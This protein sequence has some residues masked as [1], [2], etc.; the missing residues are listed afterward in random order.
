MLLLRTSSCAL[1]QVVAR[2]TP[3]AGTPAPLTQPAPLWQIG[4]HPAIAPNCGKLMG[5]RNGIDIDI[6]DP[7]TDKVRGQLRRRAK[8]LRKAVLGA[9][10]KSAK[11]WGSARPLPLRPLFVCT[12]ADRAAPSPFAL[13]FLPMHYTSENVVEGKAAARAELR[14]R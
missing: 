12:P 14:K 9:S 5:V 3:G 2:A 7:E 6:W 8:E 1:Q 4:G 10:N 11:P 13:Q